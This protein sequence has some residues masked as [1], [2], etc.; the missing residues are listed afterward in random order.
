MGEG[1]S[2]LG[3]EDEDGPTLELVDGKEHVFEGQE[4]SSFESFHLF[5]MELILPAPRNLL[6]PAFHRH[7][8]Q[9]VCVP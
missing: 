9:S 1:L 7:H 3:E 4:H 6:L 2:Q 5:S 8:L